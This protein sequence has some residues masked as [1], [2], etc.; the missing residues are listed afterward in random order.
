VTLLT[1]KT[2]VRILIENKRAVGIELSDNGVETIMAGEVVLPVSPT[3]LMHSGD[4]LAQ[5]MGQHR[6]AVIVDVRLKRAAVADS[7]HG[8]HVSG[9]L[10]HR[11]PLII[12]DDV[13][14]ESI[15]T[16]ARDIACRASEVHALAV[17]TLAI[18]GPVQDDLGGIA[19]NEHM[20][21]IGHQWQA[22]LDIALDCG[23]DLRVIS[24]CSPVVRDEHGLRGVHGHLVADFAGVK[25]LNQR[26]DNVFGLSRERKG[27]GHQESPVRVG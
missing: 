26:R 25:S 11:G 6:I 4:G 3:I 1:G 14:P 7:C 12:V 2:V 10:S 5:Q 17:R 13:P 22:E 8:A 24:D 16:A 23:S 9:G 18:N 19:G 20:A 15:R 27:V 21:H